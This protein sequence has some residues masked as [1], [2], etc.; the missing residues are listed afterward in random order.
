MVLEIETIQLIDRERRKLNINL[1]IHS[2]SIG[3]FAFILLELEMQRL[4]ESATIS[5]FFFL[6]NILFS[7]QDVLIAL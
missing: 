3:C 5:S 4:A 6:Q 2:L 1:A 7:Y